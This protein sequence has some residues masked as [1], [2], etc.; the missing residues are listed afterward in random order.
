MPVLLHALD[1]VADLHPFIGVVVLA[2]K[3]VYTLELK[4][5]ENDKKIIALYVEMKDMMGVL[6]ELVH[7]KLL[8]KVFQGPVWDGKLLAFVKLFT[9]RRTQFV[10]E[11]SI[12][13]SKGVDKANTKL[14][15]V[16]S[17]TKKIDEKMDAMVAM[18]QQ[19]VS[20]EQKE[21][22]AMVDAQ[23]GI[24]VVRRNDKT[25]RELRTRLVKSGTNSGG[26]RLG[27]NMPTFDELKYDLA[28]EPD[29]AMEH[30]MTLFSR[31]FAVQKRQIIDEMTLVVERASDRI[32]KEV[33]G[34]AYERI[35]DRFIHDLW[36]AMGWRGN[37]KARHFV[38]ALRDCYVELQS[39]DV[40]PVRGISSLVGNQ[41]SDAWAI[42]FIELSRVQPILEAFDDDASGFI[43]V[44]EMNRFTSSRRLEWSL[45]HWVA[46]WAAGWK[47][48]IID[49][50]GTIEDMFAKMEGIYPELLP[51]NRQ[52][53]DEYFQSVWNSVH[54]LAATVVNEETEWLPWDKFRKHIEDEEAHV[55][56]RFYRAAVHLR[57]P[58]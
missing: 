3:A 2:F 32:I 33:T 41:N 50:A 46:F 44:A 58:P 18:F 16:D 1:A 7:K 23:G 43:T 12:H 51:V 27:V 29:A 30:N 48:S 26:V 19:L 57:A 34:G 14:D 11:L 24:A 39:A 35:K 42:E 13:T 31:K 22:S 54:T 45:A 9:E 8:A 47:A 28:V 15:G 52:A 49:Y 17:T 25:L 53:F 38:L 36:K 10:F 37:V 4:R 55:E 6:K 56:R 21:L 20:K 5:R 40:Q